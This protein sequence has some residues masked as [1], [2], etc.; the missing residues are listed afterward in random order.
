MVSDVF[1]GSSPYDVAT[2]VTY[3]DGSGD[4]SLETSP[5]SFNLSEQVFH[6]VLE[7]QTLQN[8]AHQYYGDSGL[9]YLIAEANGIMNPFSN[10]LY[11][12]QQLKIPNYG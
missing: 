3:S 8:I 10:E 2:L 4:I 7:G 12:G 5:V 9:W 1:L 6:T 11:T